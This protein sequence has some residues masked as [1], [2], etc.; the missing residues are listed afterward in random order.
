MRLRSVHPGVTV[1]EV[2]AH[3]LR[4][5]GPAE[6]PVTRLPGRGS[7]ALIRGRLDPDGLREREWR[8]PHAADR[9]LGISCPVVRRDGWWPG[10]G[11]TSAGVGGGGLGLIAAATMS[12]AGLRAAIAEVRERTGAPSG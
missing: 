10:R 2:G 3:R 6:A 1:A 4:A 12:A 7:S 5:A 9:P 11:W 8:D